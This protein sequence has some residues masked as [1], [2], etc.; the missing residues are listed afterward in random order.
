M[1]VFVI[2]YFSASCFIVVWRFGFRNF[3]V[4]TVYFV[5]VSMSFLMAVLIAS[6]LFSNMPFSIR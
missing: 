2:L 5:Y 6:D 3:N 4:F 1:S